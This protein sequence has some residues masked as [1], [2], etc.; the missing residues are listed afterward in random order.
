[1]AEGVSMIHLITKDEARSILTPDEHGRYH[2]PRPGI[3][4]D[5]YLLFENGKW[6]AID[7]SSADAWTEEF[8]TLPDALRW[9][10]SDRSKEDMDDEKEE[11][12]PTALANSG[13]AERGCSA[14]DGDTG[15]LRYDFE[16]RFDQDGLLHLHGSPVEF[17]ELVTSSYERETGKSCV[18]WMHSGDPEIHECLPRP[19]E[20]ETAG[21]TDDFWDWMKFAENTAIDAGVRTVDE[22]TAFF[23][24]FLTMRKSFRGGNMLSG[25]N[26]SN[27]RNGE[28]GV[29][30][31]PVPEKSDLEREYDRIREVA[32]ANKLA[33]ETRRRNMDAVVNKAVDELFKLVKFVNKDGWQVDVCK[34]NNR[35]FLSSADWQKTVKVEL[36]PSFSQYG[37]FIA[38]G[39]VH[40]HGFTGWEPLTIPELAKRIVSLLADKDN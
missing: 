29:N 35:H 16:T 19:D 5:M 15:H 21:F 24:G 32:E 33:E 1:M 36:I 37:K 20:Y 17:A 2:G 28:V 30:G 22:M 26:R 13:A 14:D 39:H 7:N 23:L 40:H 25:E 10:L 3:E 18:N 31:G 12:E 11:E 6:T 34:V 8:D 4:F 9:L 38:R 27:P